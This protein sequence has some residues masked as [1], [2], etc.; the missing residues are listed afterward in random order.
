[1]QSY[2]IWNNRDCRSLGITLAGPP[3]IIRPE[4]RVEHVTIPGRPG[5]LTLVEGENIFNAYIQTVTINVKGGPRVEEVYKWL[6]G[7]GYV[8]FCGEPDR[9]QKARVIGAI[10]S[11]KHSR[12]LDWWSGE[13]QFYCQPL[14]ELLFDKTV[15]VSLDGS[16]FNR[17]DVIARPK[18]T[19]Q[20]TGTTVAI[21]SGG[22]TLTISGATN[23]RTYYIDCDSRI[24]W[25]GTSTITV[26]TQLSSGDF[27]V[28]DVGNNTLSGS[29][30]S[31][32]TVERR[33]RFL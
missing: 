19:V 9:R 4:E 18:I 11:D 24:I 1:M 30:W 28:L 27:P 15:S 12:N 22:N 23:G 32:A 26:D 21:S 7:S 20:A 8:T 16:V 17:G 25:H 10:T 5:D 3:P 33:E 2:F 29:G 31:A 6:R 14:K 13:V